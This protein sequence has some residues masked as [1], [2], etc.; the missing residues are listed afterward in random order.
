LTYCNE[1]CV[2]IGRNQNPWREA[3]PGSGLPV[4][5]RKSGGGAVYH[6][7]GNLNWSFLLPR[8]EWSVQDALD[9]VKSAMRGLGI[10][11]ESDSRGALFL[12]GRKVCG[13]ARRFYRSSVLIHGT[14]LVS[15]DLDALRSALGGLDFMENRGIASV[16]SPVGNL[17]EA[18]HGLTTEDVRDALFKELTIRYGT[19]AS[20]E[21]GLVMDAD[22]L[23]D[24]ERAHGS[25]EW[26]YGSTLPFSVSLGADG[27]GPFLSVREG[28]VLES[29]EDD[30]GSSLY[31]ALEPFAERPFDIELLRAARGAAQ[32]FEFSGGALSSFE[33]VTLQMDRERR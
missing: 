14:F 17:A 3:A 12:D 33:D 19:G 26:V 29:E 10:A 7:E 4:F 2:V 16:P 15:S 32:G 9:F 18:A 11:L 21:P 6:D 24:R 8:D 23:T 22:A 28:R 30:I 1:P 20:R 31:R 13:T 25:W 5:R 27:K